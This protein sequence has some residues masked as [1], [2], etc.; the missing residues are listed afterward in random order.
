VGS[1][2]E[3]AKLFKNS[4]TIRRASSVREGLLGFSGLEAGS[5][6]CGFMKGAGGLLNIGS[7]PAIYGTPLFVIDLDQGMSVRD[8]TRKWFGWRGMSILPPKL[9]SLGPRLRSVSCHSRTHAV[10][11]KESAIRSPRRRAPDVRDWPSPRL[12]RSLG[13]RRFG[14]HPPLRCPNSARSDS[15]AA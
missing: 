11:Q 14:L 2:K 3:L 6:S 7:P 5:S 10:Q 9:T 1:I 8:Q 4:A 15:S 13:R 12:L